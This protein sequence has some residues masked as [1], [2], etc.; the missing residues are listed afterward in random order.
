MEFL[1]TNHGMSLP[2]YGSENT[3]FH[4]VCSFSQVAYFGGSQVLCH[5]AALWR[6]HHSELGS[7]LSDIHQKPCK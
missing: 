2:R 7:R 5:E 3:V 4:L 6:S 1:L